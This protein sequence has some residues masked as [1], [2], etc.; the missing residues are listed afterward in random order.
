MNDS[1]LAA[2]VY[3]HLGR[4][5]EPTRTRAMK[6]AKAMNDSAKPPRF[7]AVAFVAAQLKRNPADYSVTRMTGRP[8]SGTPFYG[9]QELRELLDFIY[10]GPPATDDEKIVGPTR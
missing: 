4:L 9:R 7:A 6:L 10:G 2:L 1:E 8:K 3:Q 5:D